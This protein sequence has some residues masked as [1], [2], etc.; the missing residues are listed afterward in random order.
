M[1]TT[2][3]EV[4]LNEEKK[5]TEREI[6]LVSKDGKKFPILSTY[7]SIS[8]VLKTVLANDEKETQIPMDGIDGH[9]L[10]EIINYMKMQK[11]RDMPKIKWPIQ[12]KTMKEICGKG[13]EDC[14]NF[15]DRVALH[16]KNFYDFLLATVHLQIDGLQSL[17]VAKIACLLKWC[18]AD[19]LD[20]VLDPAI[21][22]GKLLPLRKEIIKKRKDDEE[23]QKKKA[24]ESKKLRES[25]VDGEKKKE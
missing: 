17:G 10:E 7:A 13:N 8:P 15:I 6:T 12:H 11:G 16:R 20:R 4:E 21:T 22:D 18:K 19:D 9:I 25:K 2:G 3:L 1:A 5:V 23:A 24:E 14:A